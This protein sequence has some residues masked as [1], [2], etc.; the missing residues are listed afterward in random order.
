VLFIQVWENF[1]GYSVA[2]SGKVFRLYIVND[3]VTELEGLTRLLGIVLKP[4]NV[5]VKFLDAVRP[6]G[7]RSRRANTHQKDGD[8]KMPR[9]EVPFRFARFEFGG[10]FPVERHDSWCHFAVW[11]TS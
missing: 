3:H 10:K 8:E 7:H 2:N 1:S 4:V 11:G 9:N 5:K 6:F